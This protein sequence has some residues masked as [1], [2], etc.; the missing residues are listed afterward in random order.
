[1]L[2]SRLPKIICPHKP[3]PKQELFLSLDCH[4]AM[5]GGAAG[6]GKSDALLMAFLQHVDRPDYRGL[7]LR[8]R[9]VDLVRGDAILNRAK[10]WWL[11][12]SRTGIRW[13]EKEWCFHFPSGA[14]CEF[15]HVKNENDV[16][17]YQGGAWNFIGF[18]EL[19]QFTPSQYLYFFSRNRNEVSGVPLRIRASANPGGVSHAFVR[20]RF[21]SMEFAKS[22]LDGTA[23]PI[24]ARPYI[25]EDETSPTGFTKGHRYFVPSKVADNASLDQK[26]Y[27]QNLRMLDSVTRNQ[28]LSGDWLIS[29]DGRFK[30][31]WFKRVKLPEYLPASAGGYYH[32]MN[33]EQIALT[34]HPRDCI[35]FVTIDPAGT[36]RD[37]KETPSGGGVPHSWSVICTWDYSP[38][39]KLLILVSVKRMQ[40]EFPE[41]LAAIKAEY[42]RW[43]PQTIFCEVDGIGRVYFQSMQRDRLPVRALATQG[44]DKLVRATPAIEDAELGRI[45]IPEYASWLSLWEAEVFHWQALK[46]ENNDQIDAMA[47]AVQ[48]VRQKWAEPV[49]LQ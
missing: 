37:M 40:Q 41:V 26:R 18:D 14:T 49:R 45:A 25:V 32:V 15:G 33:G 3:H 9:K 11:P 43:K 39:Y 16:L 23:P 19:T 17:N 36:E 8:R 2:G 1:M 28:L 20:D 44:K 21:M 4:E 7:I 22:F 12:Y 13:S 48:V 5:F 46:T 10:R 29:A 6:G 27:K 30:P 42:Q 34:I 31:Q 24:C 47:W 35:R 38:T